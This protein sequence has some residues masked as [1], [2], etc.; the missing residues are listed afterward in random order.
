MFKVKSFNK[1]LKSGRY[2]ANRKAHSKP[3][4]PLYTEEEIRSSFEKNLFFDD[5]VQKGGRTLL[6]QEVIPEIQEFFATGS[7]EGEI[8]EFVTKHIQGL[9]DS[10]QVSPEY[11]QKTIRLT[12]EERERYFQEVNNL[13][14][15]GLVD[16]YNNGWKNANL[17]YILWLGK[18]LEAIERLGLNEEQRATAFY[19]YEFSE[20]Q[21]TLDFCWPTPFPH[22]TYD[23]LPI[24]KETDRKSVV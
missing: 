8:K 21:W 5:S 2:F 17:H 7:E 4:T 13:K 12:K 24:I 19:D 15:E 1:Y 11:L 9:K 18:S 3:E 10:I 14:Y 20:G 23:E 16:Y 22:H 6:S